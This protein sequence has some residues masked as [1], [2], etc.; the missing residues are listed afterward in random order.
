M[1]SGEAEAAPC[2][3]DDDAVAG[4]M[5]SVADLNGEVGT[6]AADVFG[7]GG[8]VLGALIGDAG[9]AVVVDDDVGSGDGVFQLQAVWTA[10]RGAAGRLAGGFV[11]HGVHDGAVGDAAGG[12]E[13]VAAFALDFFRGGALAREDVGGNADRSSYTD[14]EGGD[15]PRRA[16][17]ERQLRWNKRKHGALPK[18]IVQSGRIVGERCCLS[19]GLLGDGGRCEGQFYFLGL[20]SRRFRG[21]EFRRSSN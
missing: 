16:E 2:I 15:G 20:L 11:D 1:G 8:D 10:G 18:R 17:G 6:D 3:G 19:N 12:G 5:W 13:E 7:E 9:D 14:A 4:V 21:V